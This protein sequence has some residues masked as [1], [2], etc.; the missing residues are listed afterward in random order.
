MQSEFDSFYSHSG[1]I[2]ASTAS[3]IVSVCCSSVTVVVYRPC[4]LVCLV[5]HSGTGSDIL[6]IVVK[7]D[8][9][10]RKIQ[11]AAAKT[12]KKKRNHTASLV[13]VSLAF[14]QLTIFVDVEYVESLP[15]VF[16]FALGEIPRG[17]RL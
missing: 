14:Y 16:D 5:F 10:T 15:E 12:R 9:Q 2:T 1:T 7:S 3:C 11:H 6:G 4:G 13:I 17:S 8:G